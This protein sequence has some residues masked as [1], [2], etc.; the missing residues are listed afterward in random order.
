MC[1]ED[2]KL[3]LVLRMLPAAGHGRKRGTGGLDPRAQSS[4]LVF[5]AGR[6]QGRASASGKNAGMRLP[7]FP[8]VPWPAVWD[9]AVGMGML[10][11]LE[12]AGA[13]R[14]RGFRGPGQAQ[15]M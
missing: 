11:L 8:S 15:G 2:T 10:E 1:A 9:A 5:Q 12:D 13:T 7:M 4:P 3:C 14:G 6:A